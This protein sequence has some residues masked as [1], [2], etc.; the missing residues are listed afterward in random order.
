[1][2]VNYFCNEQLQQRLRWRKK[3]E[4]VVN[5]TFFQIINYEYTRSSHLIVIHKEAAAAAAA[6]AKKEE[7]EK[8]A[9]MD[10]LFH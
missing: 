6:K 8:Q 9:G 10:I 2:F 3:I 4:Q 7:E 5:I 1:M